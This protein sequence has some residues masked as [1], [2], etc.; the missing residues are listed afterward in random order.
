MI[1]SSAVYNNPEEAAEAAGAAG[2]GD[3]D[4]TPNADAD[5]AFAY[6]GY[7]AAVPY[8]PYEAEAA[9][10]NAEVL[11][12]DTTYVKAIQSE[13]SQRQAVKLNQTGDYVTFTLTEDTNALVLRYSMPDS[14]DGAGLDDTLSLYVN[15][16]KVRDLKKWQPQSH[17][18]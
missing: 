12:F 17:R 6:D 13:A 2:A 18:L 15:G 7:G 1:P 16:S 14:A 10:T 11:P 9:Q 5:C 8:V 4:T 3:N